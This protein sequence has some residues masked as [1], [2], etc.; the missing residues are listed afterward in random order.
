MA[1]LNSVPGVSESL[2]RRATP[3]NI[4]SV[5]ED[6]AIPFR[7]A[8]TAWPSSC[9]RIDPKKRTALATAST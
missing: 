7:I 4:Q 2:S 8:T 6:T 3:P 5:I 1:I 9:S